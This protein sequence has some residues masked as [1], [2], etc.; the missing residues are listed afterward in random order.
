MTAVTAWD[1]HVADYLRLRRQLGFK[2]TWPEHVLGQ[3]TAHLAA[4]EVEHLTVEAMA[5]WAALPREDAAESGKSRAAARMN[6]VGSF[7]AYM[8]ALDPAHEVPPRGVFSHQAR[9]TTP[10]IYTADEIGRLLDAAAGLKRYDR[11]RIFPVVFGLL[12]ATGLRIGEALALDVDEVDLDTGVITVSRGKSR[13]PRLVPTHHTTTTALSDYADWRD[14]QVHRPGTDRTQA[15]F[16]DQA[17]GRLSYFNTQYAFKH[18]R[19]AAGLTMND[20]R[21]RIHDLR[22]TF[23]VTTLLG[24]YRDGLDVAGLLPRLSTYLGH[25]HPANTYWYLSAVPELL[26]HAADRLGAMST[27]TAREVGA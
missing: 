19:E 17:G 18:V 13:D 4:A 26:A 10:Y 8:H 14:Q 2:L 21:P 24:W 12:A 6:A 9:R 1:E 20:A 22:H 11:A 25:I 23:A 7:A 27:P 16:T 15:F 3:F 5:I